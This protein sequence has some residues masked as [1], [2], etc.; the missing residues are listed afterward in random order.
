VIRELNALASVLRM[1]TRLF[2]NC[3]DGVS[4]AHAVERPSGDTNNVAFLGCHLVD[5][6]HFLAAQLGLEQRNPFA[7]ALTGITGIDEMTE[8]PTLDEIRSAWRAI[9]PILE[10][11]VA[12]L[13]PDELRVPSL[14]RFP[15]DDPSVAGMVGFLIQHES[16]HIGQMALLRKYFGYPAMKY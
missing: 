9:A 1:N 3:L 2:L 14:V 4:D 8:F 15:V 12:G 10:E 16:Y 13:S 6:R 7:E 5:S 11:C